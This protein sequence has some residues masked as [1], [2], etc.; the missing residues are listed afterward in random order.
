M[1][2][3]EVQHKLDVMNL[4][5]QMDKFTSKL[6]QEQQ[7]ALVKEKKQMSH[8]VQDSLEK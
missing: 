2:I 3:Q 6:D 7:V 4:H 1:D 8:Q 5:V